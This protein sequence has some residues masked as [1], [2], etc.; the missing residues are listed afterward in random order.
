MANKKPKTITLDTI[1]MLAYANSVEDILLH[2]AKQCF[3]ERRSPKKKRKKK[4]KDNRDWKQYNAQLIKR[5]EFYINPV[6]LETWLSEIKEINLNKV[7][8]PYMYPPSMI[9]FLAIL[10][11]KGFDY[12]ALEGIMGAISKRLGNFPVISFSQIRRR[13]LELPLQ[14]NAKSDNLIVGIDGTGVKVS[15]RGEWMRQKWKVRR[16]WIKVVIMGDTKG[17]IVDI[18]IGNEDLDER[19][20][21]RGML[22]KNK[23]NIKKALMDGLHDCEDTFDLC[24]KEGIEAGIKIRENACE[25][26]LGPRP[27]EVRKYKYLGYEEWF[28]EKEYGLRWPSSEVI[29]SGVKTIFGEFVRSHKKR[30]MYKEAKLKF[31]AYQQIKD[32]V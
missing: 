24:D 29:F 22:R 6:F 28:K 2:Y 7:G 15:N 31:W 23:K 30:N 8:Q 27:R 10:H 26:G 12:R 32:I 9:R 13:I 16:G 3:I 4:Y 14:F 1:P 5:G 18:R 20:S 21:A 19:K 17:N 11:S 25:D